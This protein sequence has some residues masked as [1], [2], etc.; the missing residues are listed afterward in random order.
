MIK[1]TIH[2]GK[3]H[4]QGN[5]FLFWQLKSYKERLEAVEQIRQEYNNWKYGDKQRFQRVYTIIER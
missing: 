5:D 2:K 1:K 4:E 3:I